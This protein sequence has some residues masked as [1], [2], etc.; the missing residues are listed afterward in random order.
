MGEEIDQRAVVA[1]L[2]GLSA[3]KVKGEVSYANVYENTLIGLE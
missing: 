1:F 2:D 3:S